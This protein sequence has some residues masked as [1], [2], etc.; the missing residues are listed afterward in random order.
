M[1]E[2]N[3]TCASTMM[4]SL[5]SDIPERENESNVQPLPVQYQFKR[6]QQLL[7]N[8]AHLDDV[9]FQCQQGFV[10]DEYYNS[11]FHFGIG[12]LMPSM[13]QRV[14]IPRDCGGRL[15]GATFRRCLKPIYRNLKAGD[16]QAQ[17]ETVDQLR[18]ASQVRTSCDDMGAA[19]GAVVPAT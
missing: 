8:Y 11:V 19:V 7:A 4:G 18:F 14:L 5:Q 10:D 13:I 9:H 16:K 2:A 15:S 3:Q 1:A 12:R 6:F 17:L